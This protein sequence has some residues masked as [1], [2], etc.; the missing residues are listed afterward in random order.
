MSALRWTGE[1]VVPGD[2]QTAMD[3]L[4]E[5]L[6]RY[7]F[8]I[9]FLKGTES[10]VDAA[11]GTG[12]GTHLLSMAAN[13]VLGLDVSEE[14][15][16]FATDHFAWPGLRYQSADLDTFEL[17][18]SIDVVV[19]F[20]TIEHLRDPAGFVG[21]VEEALVPGGLFI[22]SVPPLAP[23]EWHLH[24]FDWQGA[25]DLIESTFRDVRW[26]GQRDLPIPGG[27]IPGITVSCESVPYS[28][29]YIAVC[30]K[31]GSGGV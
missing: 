7:V 8:A 21:R 14:A 19:S 28:A 29:C 13:D 9:G 18:E 3:T 15:V 1:R 12:Y 4:V 22:M 6:T 17:P 27:R 31:D 5:H 10:V 16:R 20:E 11:C 2:M 30:R 26:F 24:V 23:S 25:Q